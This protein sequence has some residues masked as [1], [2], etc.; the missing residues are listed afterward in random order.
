[1]DRTVLPQMYFHLSKQKR[2][3][4]WN[5]TMPVVYAF[6]YSLITSQWNE[7]KKKKSRYYS[8]NW[9]NSITFYYNNPVFSHLK[10]C[11]SFISNLHFLS[12][13]SGTWQKWMPILKDGEQSEFSE[14]IFKPLWD[15]CYRK[16][17]RHKDIS[18]NL[19]FVIREKDFF[20]FL[21]FI[22]RAV[23]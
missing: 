3:I 8:R 19:C 21:Y 15:E 6:K 1:M 4:I 9:L 7:K 18:N 22:F 23:L 10:S 12:T 17:A 20:I 2:E 11:F 5:C 16:I 14:K 13:C